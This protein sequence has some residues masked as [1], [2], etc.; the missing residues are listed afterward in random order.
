[1]ETAVS[2]ERLV[3]ASRR[4]VVSQNIDMATSNVTDELF[5]LRKVS[6][7]ILRP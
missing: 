1:M 2:S 3:A 7:S 4:C 6:Y 5:S